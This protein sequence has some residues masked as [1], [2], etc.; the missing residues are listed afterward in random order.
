MYF[1]VVLLHLKCPDI[2]ILILFL[3]CLMYTRDIVYGLLEIQFLQNKPL[4]NSAH[5][6]HCNGVDSFTPLVNNIVHSKTLQS[7]ADIPGWEIMPSDQWGIWVGMKAVAETVTFRTKAQT[8][9]GS[10]FET[11]IKVELGK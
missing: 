7:L 8:Q 5:K 3:H 6:V 1:N 4:W 2:S 9:P 10:F 11:R